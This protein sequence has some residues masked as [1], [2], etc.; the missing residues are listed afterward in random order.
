MKCV[1]IKLLFYH[2]VSAVAGFFL[3]LRGQI[4]QAGRT[5]RTGRANAFGVIS[6][7]IALAFGTEPL[8][9]GGHRLL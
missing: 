6:S 5:G 2:F 3:F 8:G 9:N 4:V 1:H 7:P